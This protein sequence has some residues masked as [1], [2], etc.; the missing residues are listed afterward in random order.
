MFTGIV[1]AIATIT[2][3]QEQPGLR[4]FTLEFPPGF[5][6]D[7]EIGAS[8]ATDGVCLT[9]CAL[10]TPTSAQFDVMQQSLAITTLG[11][12]GVGQR[13]NVERAAKEGAE[14]GGHILSGHVDFT[15]TLLAIEHSAS[16]YKIRFGF[17]PEFAPYLFAKGYVAINGASLTI[18]A[19]D[20]Q[21]HWLEVWLIPETRRATVFEEKAVGEQLNMEIERNTQVIVDTVRELLPALVQDLVQDLVQKSLAAA[22]DADAASAQHSDTVSKTA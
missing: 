21:A 16:N 10:P 7:L 4:T 19:I 12:Y 11:S 2:Q 17:A 3:V 8:V 22:R 15:A 5:C 13:V 1:Q 6:Q 18:S 20:K 9:V 14:V